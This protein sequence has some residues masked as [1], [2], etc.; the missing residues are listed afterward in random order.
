MGMSQGTKTYITLAGTALV[1]Y[2]AFGLMQDYCGGHG[3]TTRFCR[4]THLSDAPAP[5]EFA[6]GFD[7]FN[8]VRTAFP[9][10]SSD[11]GL[12]AALKQYNYAD[13]NESPPGAPCPNAHKFKTDVP[14]VPG[15]T[16]GIN[17]VGW[18]ADPQHKI[19]WLASGTNVVATAEPAPPAAKPADMPVKPP[20][21]SGDKPADTSATTSVTPT[22]QADVKPAGASDYTDA[23]DFAK[24][25]TTLFPKGSAE[26]D[27]LAALKAHH[28]KDLKVSPTDAM[29]ADARQFS[30]EIKRNSP[31][32]AVDNIV[33]WCSDKSEK[34]TWIDASD[35]I[36]TT[37]PALP[38]SNSGNRPVPTPA[39]DAAPP[40]P[41]PVP[42]KA[43]PR[44]ITLGAIIYK[45][46]NDW[47]LWLNGEPVRPNARP[48]E[49]IEIS[50]KP[51]AAHLQ[52]FDTISGKVV[53]I[54]L[55]EY[56][57]YDLDKHVIMPLA[58]K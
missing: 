32:E 41:A 8:R 50:V 27:L 26:Q 46:A 17:A 53:D 44:T 43:A 39:P 15:W 58:H 12:L 33:V 51:N 4:R 31:E 3:A 30:A 1:L 38:A 34:I 56:S 25:V 48:T 11:A 13:T 24:H 16:S 49:L 5:V 6:D 18:C 2:Y 47:T 14:A 23:G 42:A 40:A 45:N 19:T 55:I 28:Y 37:T 21:K 22:D 52:W 54:D 36:I 7:F 35:M 29:C 20:E 57:V 10:G 9:V